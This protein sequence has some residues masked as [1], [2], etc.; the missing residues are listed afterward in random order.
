MKLNITE[1]IFERILLYCYRILYVNTS[2]FYVMLPK[3]WKT[4][5][6]LLHSFWIRTMNCEY[7]IMSP[8]LPSANK[9]FLPLWCLPGVIQQT[10][11]SSVVLSLY[12]YFYF[13]TNPLFV[14]KVWALLLFGQERKYEGE[15]TACM[16]SS[17]CVAPSQNRSSRHKTDFLKHT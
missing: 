12:Y 14:F 10:A 2:M 11:F 17:I 3:W 6:I 9:L 16:M 15:N 13:D 5:K 7:W 1:I 4:T 8:L